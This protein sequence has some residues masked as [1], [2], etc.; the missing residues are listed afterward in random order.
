L[1][2]RGDV[3]D[4]RVASAPLGSFRVFTDSPAGGAVHGE[5][6]VWDSSG[7]ERRSITS[8]I[9]APIGE[10]RSVTIVGGTH[11]P[12][13]SLSDAGEAELPAADPANTPLL[14]PI[15]FL[16]DSLLPDDVDLNHLTTDEV[17][18]LVGPYIADSTTDVSLG[19][20]DE[21]GHVTWALAPEPALPVGM[22]S[23]LMLINRRSA[24]RH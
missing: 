16:P 4:I 3:M 8:I 19:R 1:D 5:V 11:G 6:V 23:G 18:Q 21:S 13:F 20:L 2:W 24:R 12:S 9:F 14:G 7:S 17:R 10:H 22:L 15:L